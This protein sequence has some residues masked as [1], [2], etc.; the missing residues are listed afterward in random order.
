MLGI[1]RRVV[2]NFDWVFFGIAALLILA[3]L[4][5]LASAT[6]DG[7]PDFLSESVR[8]QLFALAVGGGV[9]LVIEEPESA[10]NSHVRSPKNRWW[11]RCGA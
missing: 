3:G 8:R 5:N 10:E 1:D 6:F 9:L 4:I 11:K 7:S 2:Q